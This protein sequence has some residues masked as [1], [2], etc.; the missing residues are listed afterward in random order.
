MQRLL[1][2]RLS[3]DTYRALLGELLALYQAL[4]AALQAQAGA[5]WLQGLD[6]D[7]LSRAPALRA[8]LA[9]AG[10]PGD[11][12]PETQDY[13]ER[14]EHLARRKDPALL[15]HV[16]TRYLGD[17]HGGQVLR[18]VVRRQ[19]PD[20]GTAFHDFGDDQRVQG[21]RRQLVQVLAAAPLSEP[22]TASVVAEACWSFEQHQRLFD[23]LVAA[24]QD[25]RQD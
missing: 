6:L 4:E 13:V 15:G 19:H 24:A 25:A 2:G 1:A 9:P 23:A 16:Y 18:R 14:L 5:P 8:D 22:E 10:P 11:P 20:Q 12:R 17:L 3:R 7:A 21:L